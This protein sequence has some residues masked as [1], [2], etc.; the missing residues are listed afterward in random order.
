MTVDTSELDFLLINSVN[1]EMEVKE[2]IKTLLNSSITLETLIEE[3]G[4]VL[5]RDDELSNSPLSPEYDD[6]FSIEKAS[7][8]IESL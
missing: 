8:C 4:H 5:T 3:Q 7:V 6:I 1:Q 2:H